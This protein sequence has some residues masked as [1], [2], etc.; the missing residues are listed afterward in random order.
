MKPH[1]PAALAT[2]FAEH[3]HAVRRY[4]ARRIAF[5]SVDDVVADVFAIAWRKGVP[6]HARPWL[7]R[8][9]AHV[10]G[11]H[12]RSETR[13]LRHERS[14]G[15]D[16][17]APDEAER[18]AQ[19]VMVERGLADLPPNDAEILRLAYWEDLSSADIARVIGCSEGAAR[20]RLHR[21]RGR[22]QALLFPDNIDPIPT[23][24]TQETR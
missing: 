4:A 16:S 9:A 24:I 21:A 8:T 5:D 17:P 14:G 13:R 7:Y 11:H 23:L 10:I 1:D 20:V 3:S 22:L 18:I 2:L 15:E 6:P 19:Q 12:H